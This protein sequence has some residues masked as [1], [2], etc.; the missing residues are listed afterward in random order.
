M[1][2][3]K[4]INKKCFIYFD[5]LKS[6]KKIT[7]LI[8][9][10][11]IILK[12]KIKNVVFDFTKLKQQSYSPVHVS[13]AGILQY[14]K[15]TNKLKFS[16]NGHDE[17]YI[18]HTKT[19]N[20]LSVILNKNIFEKNIFD[21]VI[22]FETSEDVAYISDQ[23]I[24]QLKYKIVC[25]EGV[26][27]G[28]SWCMNEIMD[29]VFNHSQ[30]S[31]GYIMVQLH[32]KKKKVSISI[33]D[34]GQGILNSIKQSGEYN[35]SNSLEAINLALGK[36]VSG[37]RTVGQGNGMW[38]LKQIVEINK[39]HLSIVTGNTMM[40]FDFDKN[41]NKTFD[42]IA[43]LSKK[44]QGTRI[45]FTLN[46]DKLINI[47]EALDN[48]IPYEKINRD[49]DEITTDEGWVIFSVKNEAKEGTGT[50]I[51]GSKLKKHII[52]IAKCCSNRIVID[53]SDIEI[54]TSSF[55]DEFIGKLL[56]E[57]GVL[58]FMDRFRLINMNKYVFSMLEKAIITRKNEINC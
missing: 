10:L 7:D 26:L 40:D 20:P 30:T 19:N 44:S 36:G 17:L 12:E 16:F 57:I 24:S 11:N 50:R 31:K 15:E 6:I 23:I 2:K 54:V 49:L 41:T 56:L 27:V 55:A 58:Q 38:G 37:N 18:F 33:Y 39:G 32:E 48:Y 45:D 46:F 21:K 8:N 47:N 5:T 51:S 22:M 42:N 29:N 28:L 13:I 53:F 14:Y 25:E 43:Y 35:P 52:N 1:L 4:I 3:Y 9:I 34:T